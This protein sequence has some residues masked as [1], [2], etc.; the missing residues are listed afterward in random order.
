MSV[1]RSGEPPRLDQSFPNF[2]RQVTFLSLSA[3]QVL[4]KLE[5]EPQKTT[6][7]SGKDHICLVIA[8]MELETALF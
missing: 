3:L 7:D 8:F 6:V 2:S 4:A 1:F 5:T